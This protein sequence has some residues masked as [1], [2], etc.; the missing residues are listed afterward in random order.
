[1]KGA[2]GLEIVRDATQL[3][4]GDMM[5]LDDGFVILSPKQRSNDA[6]LLSLV[7]RCVWHDEGGSQDISR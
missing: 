7:E 5:V 1:M 3:P 6:F 4:L 2:M